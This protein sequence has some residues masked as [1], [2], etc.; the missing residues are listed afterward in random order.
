MA[1]RD[2]ITTVPDA[3]HLSP[4]RDVFERD[5]EEDP[6]EIKVP[7]ATGFD[8]LPAEIKTLTKRFLNSL[9]A[10]VHNKPVTT[11]TLSSL[12]Q[13]FYDTTAAS[14]AS[15]LAA[16]QPIAAGE[17]NEMLTPVQVSTLRKARKLLD[18]K[19]LALEEAVE[20]TVC[21]RVYDKLYQ[22]KTSDDEARDAKL[23][24]KIASLR[25]VGIGLKELHMDSDPTKDNVRQIAE[26]KE[27]EINQSLASA[28]E[29]IYRMN[30]ERY[31]AAKLRHLCDAHKCI[32][33][34]L[35]ELFPSSSSADE[36]LPTL[37]YTLITSTP[38][39]TY[40]ISNLHFIQ[41]FRANSRFDGEAAY[42]LVN[43]EAAISFLETVDLS[44]LR[45]DE[46]P[47]GPIKQRRSSSKMDH[48]LRTTD[49][50]DQFSPPTRRSHLSPTERPRATTSISPSRPNLTVRRLSSL[51]QA[52]DR[53]EA[54]RDEIL[55][56]ADKVY[57]SINGTLENSFQFVFGR[58]KDVH[59]PLPRTLEEA[60]RFI[61]SH[62]DKDDLSSADGNES[63]RNTPDPAFHSTKSKRRLSRSLTEPAHNQ[64]PT[65][66]QSI[67][68][69]NKIS[70][71][72]GRFGR[73]S[74]SGTPSLTITQEKR[75]SE[76]RGGQAKTESSRTEPPKIETQAQSRIEID[77]TEEMNAKETLAELKRRVKPPSKRFLEVR[78][79]G[80]LRLDEIEGLLLEYRQLAKAV[81]WA[82][83][84]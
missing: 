47:T 16:T 57:D 15:H 82:V 46:L 75:F 2:G 59:E 22:H 53:L 69:L 71:P 37:I 42:C 34:T 38:G 1:H 33:N 55:K 39:D 49:E 45:A 7:N 74:V 31:P 11:D 9:G 28:R 65:I 26:E 73:P 24:S 58:F 60:Q 32:V 23:R 56:T 17:S 8:E 61:S 54:G 68:P 25:V 40:V 72:F 64:P 29:A 63:G 20:R 5:D 77:P 3:K 66:F 35:T 4:K 14:I 70:M 84:D 76:S 41:R 36:V 50:S 12:F 30:D 43:L 19:Q 52:A 13:D 10:K 67:N 79:A 78:N 51:A 21:E 48:P 44:S 81:G 62:L 83:T 27:E 18:R 6:P 80:E